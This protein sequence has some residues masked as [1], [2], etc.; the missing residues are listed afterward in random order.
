MCK[1]VV[2]MVE[3]AII[4]TD[5]TVFLYSLKYIPEDKRRHLINNI[6]A[7]IL[8]TLE[9]PEKKVSGLWR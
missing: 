7:V 4:E 9:P 5:V 2:K 6:T 8:W 1:G 3:K